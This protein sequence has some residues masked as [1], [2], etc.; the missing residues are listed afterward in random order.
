MW[1]SAVSTAFVRWPLCHLLGNELR[2]GMWSFA[3]TR[4]EV[5]ELVVVQDV[6]DGVAHAEHRVLDRTALLLGIG[7]VAAFLIGGLA[8]AADR[9][10][11][12]VQN[13]DHLAEGDVLGWFD[14]AVAAG[15]PASAA[16]E[17]RVLEREQDLLEKLDRDLLPL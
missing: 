2:S 14:E 13:S 8:D 3:V 16:Q 17:T 1:F 6:R 5:A 9:R 7:A 4:R 12:T 11:W 15:D 10:Q